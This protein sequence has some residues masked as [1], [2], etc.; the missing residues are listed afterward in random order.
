MCTYLS[1]NRCLLSLA[2]SWFH[3][4]LVSSK[5]SSVMRLSTSS[6]LSLDVSFFINT[7]FC[8]LFIYNLLQKYIVRVRNK[9]VTG[10]VVTDTFTYPVSCEYSLL[11]NI[12]TD[13]LLQLAFKSILK[14]IVFFPITTDYD[15]GKM[16]WYAPR[17]LPVVTKIFNLKK[18]QIFL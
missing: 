5:A 3:K 16:F 10:K 14:K 17:E 15:C 18:Y 9:T 7:Y 4:L 11:Q 13:G 8:G 1:N 12:L 2:T 6:L